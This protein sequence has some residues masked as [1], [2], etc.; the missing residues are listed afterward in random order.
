M[1]LKKLGFDS[2]FFY[3]LED[4]LD[5]PEEAEKSRNSS[6]RAY[7]RD[8]KAMAATPADVIE[9]PN[10]YVFIVDMPGIKGSEIKVQVENDNVLVVSGERKRD[11]EKDEKEGVKYVRMERRVG[12]FMRKFNLPDNANMDNISAVSQDGVLR[13][14]VEKL[15]P[16]QPKTKTIQV[17]VA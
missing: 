6:S 13:V 9:Y 4:L 15:P 8:A 1:D 17:Q 16:P 7:V 3:V 2:P 11:K 10:S 14:T 12:K 5:V